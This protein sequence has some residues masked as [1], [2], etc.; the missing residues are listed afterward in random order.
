MFKRLKKIDGADVILWVGRIGVV[1]L[2][3]TYLVTHPEISNRGLDFAMKI[4]GN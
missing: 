3:L 4:V 2:L 1:A